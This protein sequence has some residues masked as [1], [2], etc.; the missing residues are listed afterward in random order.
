MLKKDSKNALSI[1]I[2][3]VRTYEFD[4]HAPSLVGSQSHDLMA[5]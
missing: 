4:V 3:N 5:V 1:R 2:P